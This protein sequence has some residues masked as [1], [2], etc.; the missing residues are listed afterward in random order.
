MS[1][2]HHRQAILD[3]A[4]ERVWDLV[5]DPRRYPEW[6]PLVLEVRGERFDEGF[7]YEQ[8]TRTSRRG[9][10]ESTFMIDRLEELEEVR[11]TCDLSG[12]YARWQL[13]PARG[14]TFVDVEIGIDPAGKGLGYR[15][16]DL[17]AATFVYRRWADEAIGAL[18]RA[19]RPAPH[20]TPDTPPGR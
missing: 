5:G 10:T 16:F 4:P 17:T 6:W 18:E 15:V 7:Q 11:V 19:A 2:K 1:T 3:A 8:V 12:T 9:T 14:G 20:P 13:T